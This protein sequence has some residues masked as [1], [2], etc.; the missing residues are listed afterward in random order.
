VLKDVPDDTPV[1]VLRLLTPTMTWGQKLQIHIT[2][3]DKHEGG[4]ALDIVRNIWS[5]YG[6]RGLTIDARFEGAGAPAMPV[7]P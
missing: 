1:S 5:P 7:T 3:E 4:I 2:D 6:E